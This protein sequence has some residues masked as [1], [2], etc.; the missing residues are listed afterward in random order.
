MVS[1]QNFILTPRPPLRQYWIPFPTVNIKL[2]SIN[3]KIQ[4][5]SVQS[6]CSVYR[7]STTCNI[8]SFLSKKILIYILYAQTV[9]TPECT[10]FN[11][12]A[13][14]SIDAHLLHRLLHFVIFSRP[15]HSPMRYAFLFL[16][17][18]HS[19]LKYFLLEYHKL[20]SNPNNLITYNRQTT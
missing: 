11:L 7:C 19:G 13:C 3:F 20:Y 6:K 17:V 12:P 2:C 15:I 9:F 5:F 18:F 14:K 16:A 8:I 4:Q 1:R 10:K